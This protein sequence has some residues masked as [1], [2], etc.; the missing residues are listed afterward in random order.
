MTGRIDYY[1]YYLYILL[2]ANK[3]LYKGST[4]DIK[5]RIL[6]HQKGLV[7]STRNFRPL[8]LIHF[9]C[10]VLKTD[11]ERREKFLK[12]TEGRRLLKQQIRDILN[13]KGL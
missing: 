1:M 11:A 10:Y 12:T 5:R 4:S 8:S 9:E 7:A 6:E 2:L 3:D 13:N